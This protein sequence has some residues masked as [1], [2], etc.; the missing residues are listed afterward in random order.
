M[1]GTSV[2]P[3]ADIF[4]SARGQWEWDEDWFDNF[5]NWISPTP[6]DEPNRTTMKYEDFFV[7]HNHCM[8][9][10]QEFFDDQAGSPSSHSPKSVKELIT[11]WCTRR[12]ESAEFSTAYATRG[13][14]SRVV[15]SN[16]AIFPNVEHSHLYFGARLFWTD[17]W[18]CVPGYEYLCAGPIDESKSDAFLS[19]CL[20]RA[21]PNCNNLFSSSAEQAKSTG[22]LP[23]S[24]SDL[25]HLPREIH[26]LIISHLSL[27]DAISFSSSCR[28]L[29]G[30]CDGTFWRLQTMRLHSCWLWELR[31][32]KFSSPHDNWKGLLQLLNTTRS[33]IQEGAQ[34]FWDSQFKLI[35][36][37]DKSPD[38]SELSNIPLSLGL[39]NRQ[40]IWMCLESLGTLADWEIMETHSRSWDSSTKIPR[41]IR[42][43]YQR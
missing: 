11:A 36:T 39:R 8:T 9:I 33:Q 40:R 32:P 26:D 38:N 34:P 42:S 25:V 1:S 12:K 15:P 37:G 6:E 13:K 17:P 4:V 29:S 20:A 3:E 14:N 30:I 24:H 16:W 27:K 22:D 35:E 2:S 7:V 43:K 23:L 28:Q 19:T 41:A 31:D 21:Y 18:D 10:L 5:H